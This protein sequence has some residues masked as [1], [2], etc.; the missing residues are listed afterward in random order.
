MFYHSITKFL[1]TFKSFWQISK[2]FVSHVLDSWPIERKTKM[3]LMIIINTVSNNLQSRQIS[4]CT[5]SPAVSEVPV[6]KEYI[7]TSL[8][9][10]VTYCKWKL[11]YYDNRML[12]QRM[13]HWYLATKHRK[14]GCVTTD[15]YKTIAT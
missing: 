2:L 5:L 1:F 14:R 11:G 15:L 7:V 6:R 13:V 3:H 12:W 8:C 9:H 4:W 10:L